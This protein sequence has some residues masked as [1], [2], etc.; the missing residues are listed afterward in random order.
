LA[1]FVPLPQIDRHATTPRKAGLSQ[2][3]TNFPGAFHGPW[4]A[5]CG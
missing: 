1:V 4:A 2:E 3:M 5:V